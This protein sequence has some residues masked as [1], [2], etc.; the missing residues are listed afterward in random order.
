MAEKLDI[1]L[2]LNAD[3][4]VMLVATADNTLDTFD[5]IP[6]TFT[7][8][9]VETIVTNEV[10]FNCTIRDGYVLDTVTNTNE[11][12]VVRC[13][14]DDSFVY[15]WADT[16]FH[17]D[18][19]DTI[20]IST[21]AIGD[22]PSVIGPNTNLNITTLANTKWEFTLYPT[23][24]IELLWDCLPSYPEYGYSIYAINTKWNNDTN[25][26]LYFYTGRPEP[27][28]EVLIYR[29]TDNTWYGPRII[30]IID[31]DHITEPAV[32]EFFKSQATLLSGGPLGEGSGDGGDSG[33]SGDSGSSGGSINIGPNAQLTEF[34][35]G[36]ADAIRE[37]TG[38]SDPINPQDFATTIAEMQTGGGASED[39]LLEKYVEGNLITLNVSTLTSVASGAFTR[40]NFYKV[41]LP[42]CTTI[43]SSAFMSCT[44]LI[45]VNLPKCTL[46][47]QN[48]FSSCS[49]LTNINIP[50]CVSIYSSA[51]ANSPAINV[52]LPKCTTLGYYAFSNT[53]IVSIALPECLVLSTGAF[54]SARYLTEISLPKCS[55][56]QGNCF[57]QCYNLI[58]IYAPEVSRIDAGA[59]SNCSNLAMVSFPKL[60]KI[61][62]Y[63]FRYCTNL[64]S[65]YLPEC[66]YINYED[67]AYCSKLTDV[68]LPKCSNLNSRPFYVCE[69]L[70]NISLPMCSYIGTSAFYSCT[71][72]EKLYLMGSSICSLGYSNAFN[73]TPMLYSSY[74]GYFGS[75][76][77][78]ASLLASYKAST[79]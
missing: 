39:E 68:S 1:R 32:I 24:N 71:K 77:V 60:T 45:D 63:T 6:I 79:N 2:T 19:I 69:S 50:E 59:F 3:S 67:F 58:S 61:N 14:T 36:I 48:A 41:D 29:L 23:C 35:T 10:R 66:S 54:M 44:S 55:Y 57:Y 78:P 11:H 28:D 76:Y 70:S 37:K 12:F 65:V 49:Q 42:N 8:S 64:Q 56:I 46:I 33:D 43:G 74:L 15:T 34:L 27:Y 4:R 47:Y 22:E 73:N 18:I 16:Y 5:G 26:G 72:L 9:S 30:E 75:I 52:S 13:I 17:T 25:G 51:F 38:S 7:S 40:K 21:R 53:Q 31:G 62:Q 20:T